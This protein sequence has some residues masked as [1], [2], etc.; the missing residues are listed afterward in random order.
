[1]PDILKDKFQIGQG[2]AGV[3]AIV[4]VQFASLVGAGLGGRVALS[5]SVTDPVV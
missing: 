3:S 1:M 5:G 4:C 2:Q